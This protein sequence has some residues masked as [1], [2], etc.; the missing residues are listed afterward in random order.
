MLTLR[1]YLFTVPLFTSLKMLCLYLLARIILIV[2]LSSDSDSRKYEK[3]AVREVPGWFPGK[4]FN[5]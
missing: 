1:T 3:A 4:D 5:V 2:Y